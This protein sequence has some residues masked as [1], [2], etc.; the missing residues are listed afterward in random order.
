MGPRSGWTWGGEKVGGGRGQ[1]RELQAQK[2]AQHTRSAPFLSPVATVNQLQGPHVLSLDWDRKPLAKLWYLPRLEARSTDTDE[3]TGHRNLRTVGPQKR[4]LQSA[5]LQRLH[6]A[7][8]AA[9]AEWEGGIKKLD[10]LWV[11][12]C[13]CR[14]EPIS[15]SDPSWNC[16]S[17]DLWTN[18][19]VSCGTVL[20]VRELEG[21][22][23]LA[24]MYHN[25]I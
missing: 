16:G 5:E 14:T 7:R 18:T 6:P 24:A 23:E 15:Y 22:R 2:P 12:N 21:N 19:T 10:G 13:S 9:A 11:V 17:L 25:M 20:A 4:R 1:S 8:R 3:G